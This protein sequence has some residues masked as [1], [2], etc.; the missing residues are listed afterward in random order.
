M[1]CSTCLRLKGDNLTRYLGL[2]RSPQPEVPKPPD[3]KAE[4]STNAPSRPLAK[5]SLC[6]A[7]NLSPNS[8]CTSR[9]MMPRSPITQTPD[10]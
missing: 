7:K 3:L 4:N 10:S 8:A 1:L 2:W 6:W 5:R 9:R